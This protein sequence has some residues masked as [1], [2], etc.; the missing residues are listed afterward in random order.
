MNEFVADFVSC[1]QQDIDTNTLSV[2]TRMILLMGPP[3]G[4]DP[5]DPDVWGVLHDA[6]MTFADVQVHPDWWQIW[7][8]FG[9]TQ[10]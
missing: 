2:F 8:E 7:Q 6:A 1:V 9:G 4:I 3:E 10:E 5:E